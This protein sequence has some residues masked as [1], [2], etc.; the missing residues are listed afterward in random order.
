MWARVSMRMLG[1]VR[2][3]FGNPLWDSA[4]REEGGWGEGGDVPLCSFT[5]R[6][7]VGSVPTFLQ[8]MFDRENIFTAGEGSE[9]KYMF[10][11]T[12]HWRWRKLRGKKTL[13]MHDILLS[14]SVCTV[15]K[16]GPGKSHWM[17]GH[18]LLLKISHNSLGSCPCV[19]DRKCIH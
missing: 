9:G 15:L 8:Q 7:R 17:S 2:G 5:D 13:H 10:Y 11:D 19:D 16:S 4:S 14:M 12:S 6:K 1:N 3:R 18:C